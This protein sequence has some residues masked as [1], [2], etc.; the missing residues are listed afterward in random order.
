[1]AAKSF[2][3]LRKTVVFNDVMKVEP[4]ASTTALDVFH[5]AF[6]LLANVA[7][8]EIV[9]ARIERDLPEANRKHWTSLPGNKVRLVLGLCR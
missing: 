6:G 9:G 3:S 1:M 2:M 4:A 8:E 7:A 5:C